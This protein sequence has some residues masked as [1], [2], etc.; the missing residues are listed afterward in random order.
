LA[1]EIVNITKNHT[2][3]CNCKRQFLSKW[4]TFIVDGTVQ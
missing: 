4:N 3:Y 1:D 2:T